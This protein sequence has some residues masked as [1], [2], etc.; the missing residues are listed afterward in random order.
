MDFITTSI[1]ANSAYDVF[2][3]GLS[4]TAQTVKERLGNWIKDDLLAEAVAAELAKLE[5][6]DEMSELA[7]NR[8]LDASPVFQGMV[9][10][11][12]TQVALVAPSQINS[13]NQIHSGSGD[14]VAGN[15]NIS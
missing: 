7:I 1:I 15:K 14:N 9:R 3:N 4:L 2:K 5:V 11:I 6:N 8:R 13:V 10:D 12:N